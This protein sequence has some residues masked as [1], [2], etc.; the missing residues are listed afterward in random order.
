MFLKSLLGPARG[1]APRL[2]NKA[3]MKGPRRDA[4]STEGVGKVAAADRVFRILDPAQKL[5][6]SL[7]EGQ[8][9]YLTGPEA[10]AVRRA[11]L[12]RVLAIEDPV[13]F[14]AAVALL[15]SYRTKVK[16]GCLFLFFFPWCV[17]RPLLPPPT[18]TAPDH[19]P[20]SRSP[21]S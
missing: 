14:G 3:P 6:M 9:V 13:T 8:S 15:V 21:T 17:R 20:R 12:D 5:I 19:P 18:Q 10:D 16:V 11:D 1:A 7:A 4:N 2:D